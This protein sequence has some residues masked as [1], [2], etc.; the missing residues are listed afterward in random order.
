M[1]TAYGAVFL[2][3][4]GAYAGF[5]AFETVRSSLGCTE[6]LL[7]AL[8]DMRTEILYHRT[9]LPQ[10]LERLGK[11]YP[12]VFSPAEN[13]SE[14]VREFSFFAVWSAS[15]RCSSIPKAL[16]EPLLR[17]GEQ[18]SSGADPE[19]MLT[20]LEENVSYVR[21]SLREK[22]QTARRLYPSLGIAAGCI[23]AVL[24]L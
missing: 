23:L 19:Q 5:S 14:L 6:T 3:A 22:E 10:L 18:L 4:A 17:F 16:E 12:A 7:A 21:S 9:P 15:I 24:L 13:T 2:I 20:A 1:I 11:R 8:R